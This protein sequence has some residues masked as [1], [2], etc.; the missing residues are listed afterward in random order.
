[1]R[2]ATSPRRRPHH[3]SLAGLL[4]GLLLASGVTADIIGSDDRRPPDAAAALLSSAVGVVS[5]TG[6]GG[7][8]LRPGRATGSVVGNRRTVL[9]AAHVFTNDTGTGLAYRAEA[10][11]RFRQYDAAGELTADVGFVQAAYGSFVNNS[12]LPNQD[13]AVLKTDQALPATTH[14]L[15][16]T[17]LEFDDLGAGGRLPIAVVAFHADRRDDGERRDR[18][19][20]ALLSEGELFTVTYAGFRRL[21]HTADMSRMASGAP[22]VHRTADGRELVVGVHRSAAQYGDYNLAVPLSPELEAVLRSFAWGEAPAVGL[23]LARAAPQVM[24]SCCPV[25]DATAPAE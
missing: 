7:S 18:R 16:F 6:E 24:D 5:C 3:L 25:V 9:T 15:A 11:C 2:C 14:P 20:T 8:R 19:R 21:A 13:W 12:G 23:R 17:A 1:V 22:L 4:T 10:D